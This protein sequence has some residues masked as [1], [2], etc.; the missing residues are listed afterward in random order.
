MTVSTKSKSKIVWICQECGN[1]QNKWTGSCSAC[2][3][4]NTF[5]QEIETPQ[6]HTTLQQSIVSHPVRLDEVQPHD[7]PRYSTKLSQ[8]DRLLGGGVVV[9][10]LA[11]IA[12]DPG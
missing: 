7:I 5:V 10:S 4:W 11:L 12:G 3:E 2:A 1:R 9:G 8:C 6:R